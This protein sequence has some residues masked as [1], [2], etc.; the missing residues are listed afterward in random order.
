MTNVLKENKILW[1]VTLLLF[2]V[3]VYLALAS[4]GQ[5]DTVTKCNGQAATSGC[6][7]SSQ[8]TPK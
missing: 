6:A 3:N 2:S 8:G 7:S 1:F 5:R 4:C